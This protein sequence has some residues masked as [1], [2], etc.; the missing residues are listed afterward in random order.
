MDS[1]RTYP[2]AVWEDLWD[3]HDRLAFRH[4]DN[5]PAMFPRVLPSLFKNSGKDL[6]QPGFFEIR[7]SGAVDHYFKS[8]RPVLSFPNQEVTFGFNVG[9]RTNGRDAAHWPEELSTEVVI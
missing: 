9:T 8:V 5:M 6:F 2:T 7:Y 1:V 3:R 4:N